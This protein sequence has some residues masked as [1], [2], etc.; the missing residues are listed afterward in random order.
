MPIG[1]VPLLWLTRICATGDI[2]R[3]DPR[4]C[5]YLKTN[6]FHPQWQLNYQFTITDKAIIYHDLRQLLKLSSIINSETIIYHEQDQTVKYHEQRQLNYLF[7]FTGQ[8]NH[9]LPWT[10]KPYYHLSSTRQQK[11][12][13]LS[14]T[15]PTSHYERDEN[16]EPEHAP[17]LW[18]VWFFDFAIL[19][20]NR[21]TAEE[22]NCVTFWAEWTKR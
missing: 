1:V 12:R 20:S 18:F 9:H 7:S 13:S 2:L 11:D 10:K 3:G 16:R 21:L 8:Q 22:I 14:S 15:L 6:I 5:T 19:L 17:W 4:L